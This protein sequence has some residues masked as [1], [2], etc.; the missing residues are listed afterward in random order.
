[1]CARW[2]AATVVS[3]L[4]VTEVALSAGPAA[5]Q[6]RGVLQ[7]TAT[8][9]DV[10][11]SEAALVRTRTLLRTAQPTQA[12]SSAFGQPRIEIL[13]PRPPAPSGDGR[14]PQVI[15]LVLYLN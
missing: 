12:P 5:A 9:V 7:A 13:R 3:M 4:G 1:M 14:H 8:V 6:S 15:V 2:A 11:Q 10:R